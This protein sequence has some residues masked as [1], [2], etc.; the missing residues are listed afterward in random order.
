MLF[1][2]GENAGIARPDIFGK[3]P[4]QD[5]FAP[6]EIPVGKFR[7]FLVSGDG[8]VRS[9]GFQELGGGVFEDSVKLRRRLVGVCER[10]GGKPFAPE[11]YLPQFVLRTRLERANEVVNV[12][13]KHVSL[14]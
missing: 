12:P 14:H 2:G 7:A 8:A 4:Q 3:Q 10:G 5:V 6:P 13:R 1:C 9:L 11:F